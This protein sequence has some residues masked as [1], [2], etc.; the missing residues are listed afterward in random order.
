MNIVKKN[1]FS[2]LKEVLPVSLLISTAMCFMLFVY[3]PIEIFF[4]NRS[5]IW[6]DLLHILPV[7]LIP[8]FITLIISE[9]VFIAARIISRKLFNV[10][11]VCY[12]TAF[13]SCY[14]Q[15]NFMTSY[16]PTFD[17]ADFDWDTV[18]IQRVYSI[19]LW[20]VVFI[21]VVA[22]IKL[23]HA[24]KFR[25]LISYAGGFFCL[26]FLLSLTILC[27]MTDG[28]QINSN[29]I[30]TAD[31]EFE[32][33]TDK[34]FVILMLDA[35]D[36]GEF[37]EVLNSS[38]EYSDMLSDFTYYDDVMS[39]YPYTDLSLPFILSGEYYDSETTYEKYFLHAFTDSPL[40]D[41]LETQG[42]RLG[43]YEAEAPSNNKMYRFENIHSNNTYF[44]SIIATIKIQI[45]LMGIRY[46]PYDLKKYCKMYLGDIPRLRKYENGY[47]G[48]E[49]YDS[50]QQFYGDTNELPITL[51]ED[52]CFKFIHLEGAHL[53]YKYDKEMNV[54]NDSSSTYTGNVEACMTILTAYLQKLKD[55]DVYDN[56][57]III[58]SDHGYNSAEFDAAEGRQ[59]AILLAKGFNECHDTLNISSAPVSHEEFI[60]MA[61]RLLNGSNGAEITDY[62]EGDTR[63]R[64][65]MFFDT[66]N[67]SD[68][69]YEYLQTGSADDMDTLTPTGNIIKRH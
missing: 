29:Q 14:I 51:T 24:D 69:I 59:H 67:E 58:M 10:A 30:V 46:M 8:F 32:M 27:I 47:S 60:D 11:L 13:F 17:G 23:L 49:F 54:Y 53:P 62:K 18:S 40:F 35:V 55:N 15:G 12:T 37:S 61:E 7:C 34:N 65:Y 50:N 25:K 4:N 48:L 36:G 6:Y 43:L 3:A 9:A 44:N 33:S 66:H 2:Q 39:A 20:V 64:K 38:S 31:Y 28:A 1:K 42:Y 5:D 52:K 56:T 16:I 21:V 26:M 45:K 63:T 19:I 41:T 22:A 68:T 57:A